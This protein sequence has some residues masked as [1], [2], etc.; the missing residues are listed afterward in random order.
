MI[1]AMGLAAA[2]ASAAGAAAVSDGNGLTGAWD[3][4]TLSGLKLGGRAL[5]GVTATVALRDPRTGRPADSAQFKL[6]CQLTGRN[7]ALWLQ[8]RVTAAGEADAVADLVLR[9]EGVSLPTGNGD[10]DLLLA[11]KLVN[12]LPLCPLRRLADG[13][14]VLAMAVPADDP[15]VYAFKDL[16]GEKAV[17]LRLPLGFTRDAAP[18]LR[19]QAPFRLVLFQTDPRWHFRSVLAQ[20]YR[21]FPKQFARVEKRD[22]GWFFANEVPQIPNPQ[23]FAFFEGLGDAKVTHDR[24]LGM[25]PY[26]ETSS[27]TIHLPGPGLPQGYDEAM[28]QLEALEQA[29]APQGWEI[30]GGALDEAVKHGGRFSYRA[31]ADKPGSA[32]ARQIVPLRP[33][34]AE[35]VVVEGWSKA[36]DVSAGGNPN[37]YSIYVDCQLADGSY[38]FGQCATFRAGTHDW[39]KATFVI[40]PRQPLTDL[41]VY[42]MFRNRTGAAWFDDVRLYRQSK[43][44]EN[45]IANTDFETLGKR[46]DIQYCRDNALTDAEGRYRFIITDN[47][48]A[49]IPPAHPLSLLRFACNVDPDWQA[50]EGRPTPCGRA[51]AMY[52]NLF[53]TVDID[54]A[55][56]D[57]V[58]AWCAWYLSFRRD[59]WPAATS[60]FTYDPATFKVAQAGKLAMAKYLR[61]IGERFHPRDKTIFGNMGPST[62]AWDNYPALDIIGIESSQFRD[63]ALMGYHRFGG[64]HSPCCR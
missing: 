62:E 54:G 28:K 12:K 7:G 26:S 23:H 27:E 10:T 59:H 24:G 34:I 61:F 46:A 55:Y 33:A 35:P 5:D 57:S 43:P 9:W 2:L 49:D 14:D 38:Q 60:L 53:A 19:M 30:A 16:P 31:S 58:C 42:A 3:G 17:E 39:E 6:T 11:A 41:R 8:G 36:E 44:G 37:D 48:A 15:V 56:I 51:V 52:D 20:Y 4:Q 25:Y 18:A 45:L 63:R 21:L 1:L 47:L 50:P 40:Q 64:Y 13:S 32:F 29:R 22:G